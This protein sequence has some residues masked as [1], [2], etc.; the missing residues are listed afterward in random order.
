MGDEETP[1]KTRVI[2]SVL[3]RID[4]GDNLI[5]PI[6]VSAAV[7]DLENYLTELLKEVEEQKQKRSYKFQSP[8]TEFCT[9]LN[10][11]NK[12]ND[13]GKSGHSPMLAQRLLKHE[14]ETGIK[15]K[16]INQVTRGSFL[17]FM[18]A[19]GE[20]IS[21]L[22]VKVE[23]QSFVDEI[24]FTRR[25]GLPE[26]RKLYKACRVDFLPD[27]GLGEVSVFDTN[28][29]PAAYWWR[30]F[31]E[32]EVVRDDTEN[33]KLASEAV[34]QALGRLRSKHPA[35]HTILRNAAVAAFKQDA[36]MNYFSFVDDVFKKYQ[37]IDPDAAPAIEKLVGHLSELPTKKKFD[38]QFNLV[39][40]AVPFRKT[41]YNLSPE[42]ALVLQDGMTNISNKIWREHTLDGREVV[43]IQSDQA[44]DFVL[45]KRQ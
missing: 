45:K 30:E 33:T 28:G 39:P 22:G 43:V 19:V 41:T 27:G 40:S 5:S 36:Q 3:Y 31:L 24:E 8:A 11:F 29:S 37:P 18:Y 38:T 13:L 32:L 7:P 26:E 17:Q 16:N 35:D 23:H 21:Y 1:I 4:T 6:A 25:F 2:S 14:I 9:C 34:L 20:N 42:I 15:Y 10:G 12:E 44:R